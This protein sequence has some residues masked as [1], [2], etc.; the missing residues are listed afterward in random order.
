MAEPRRYRIVVTGL[1]KP[2]YW[3][4]SGLT[5][6]LLQAGEYVDGHTLGLAVEDARRWL[7]KGGLRLNVVEVEE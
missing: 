3:H 5:D 6:E 4:G 7:L 1:A 2:L